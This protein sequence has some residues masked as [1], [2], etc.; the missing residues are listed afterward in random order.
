ML[1]TFIFPSVKSAS[2]LV[3]DHVLYILDRNTLLCSMATKL[4]YCINRGHDHCLKMEANKL[5]SIPLF[6]SSFIPLLELINVY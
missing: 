3:V 5:F 2:Q 4:S 1:L 6:T